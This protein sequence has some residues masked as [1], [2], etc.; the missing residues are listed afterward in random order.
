MAQQLEQELQRTRESLASLGLHS[1]RQPAQGQ[2][3]EHGRGCQASGR[4]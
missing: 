1:W 3:G 4:S 2:Q